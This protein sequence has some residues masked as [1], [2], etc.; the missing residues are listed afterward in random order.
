MKKS[1]LLSTILYFFTA[2]AAL[3]ANAPGMTPAASALQPPLTDKASGSEGVSEHA[4]TPKAANQ[5]TYTVEE[6]YKNG[7]K[8]N[9]EKVIVHG[10]VV[11]TTSG[12]MGK[13]WTHIQDGTGDK[14]KGNNDLICISSTAQ[15][16]VGDKVTF[17]GTV[18][19]NPESRYRLT[20]EDATITK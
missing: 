17:T 14:E 8:L 1:V 16:T 20:L 12:I 2:I 18:T 7:Q 15:P 4:S 10:Q 13:S 5:N 19:F 9:K 3:A 11:K 6:L